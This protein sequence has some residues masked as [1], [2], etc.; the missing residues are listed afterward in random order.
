MTERC[1][2]I[3]DWSPRL[4]VQF[5]ED[6]RYYEELGQLVGTSF[7]SSLCMT[8]TGDREIRYLLTSGMP[9]NLRGLRAKYVILDEM[10]DQKKYAEELDLVRLIKE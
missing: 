10:V 9:E 6:K 1:V 4:D 8:L 2:K 7:Q 3:F 5:R